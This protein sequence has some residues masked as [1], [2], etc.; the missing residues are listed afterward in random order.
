MW[1]EGS[2][3]QGGFRGPRPLGFP[4]GEAQDEP[5]QAKQHQEMASCHLQL[6][7]LSSSQRE[8]RQQ[9]WYVEHEIQDMCVRRGRQ[10]PASSAAAQACH[11]GSGSSSFCERSPQSRAPSPFLSGRGCGEDA[12]SSTATTRPGRRER[13]CGCRNH[14][15]RGAERLSYSNC[16]SA[17]VNSILCSP[18]L[19]WCWLKSVILGWG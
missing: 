8:P 19:A 2:Q 14:I 11:Q 1:R 6:P 10:A 9:S 13:A 5:E 3:Q 18:Y 7:G 4:T 16:S 12:S 15:S 17:V